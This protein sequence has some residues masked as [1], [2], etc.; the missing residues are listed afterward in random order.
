MKIDVHGINLEVTQ[1]IQ[2]Y[3]EKKISRAV[4]FS[5][6][7]V[8]GMRVNLSC[9]NKSSSHLV[10]VIIFMP[11]GKTI[12]N[13]TRSEDM[14]ASVD[15]ACAAIERQLKKLKEK[16]IDVKRHQLMEEKLSLAPDLIS[17]IAS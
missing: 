16:I 6:E 2:Q 15:I 13:K 7:H 5:L 12:Y 17:A 4:K 3:V 14:Y 9:E 10:E 8:S 11:G 1:S